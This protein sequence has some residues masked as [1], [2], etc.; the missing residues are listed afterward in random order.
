MSNVS[1][2]AGTN[3]RVGR[4]GLQVA[5]QAAFVAVELVGG[6]PG[7]GHPGVE[8]VAEHLAG[9]TV[10]HAGTAL[11]G[12]RTVTSGGRVLAVVGSGRDYATAIAHAYHGVDQITFDGMQYR[13][14]IGRRALGPAT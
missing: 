9:V 7:R 10:F 3:S 5:A 11:R 1:N 12:G 2:D 8:G 14:D 4:I 13:K 6:H